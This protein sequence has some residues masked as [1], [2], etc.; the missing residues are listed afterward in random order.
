MAGFDDFPVP[1]VPAGTS[2]HDII[3]KLLIPGTPFEVGDVVVD[4][5]TFKGFKQSPANMRQMLMFVMAHGDLDAIV[6]EGER[7]SFGDVLRKSA[8]LARALV[9]D[10]GVK[11][12]DRVAIAMRN[13]PEWIF[14][15]LAITSIGGVA[16]ALNAWWGAEEL[17][18]A[19]KDCGAK[20]VIADEKRA[21][22]IQT[23]SK[24]DGI[25][26]IV[27]RPEGEMPA[28]DVDLATL[29][30]G[31]DMA[32]PEV[33]V[34]PDD[35]MH[36]LYTSGS[37]GF[38][39]GAVHTH[40]STVTS[41]MMWLVMALALKVSR[42]S[43]DESIQIATLV[44]VP[45]FHVTGLIP[46]MLVSLMIGRKLVVMHKW[47]VDRACQLIEEEKVTGFTGV[48][49][50]GYELSVYEG[51]T[52]YD[53]SSLQD[54]GGGGAARPKEHVRLL[55]D[56]LNV[57]PGLGYGL[58]ETNAMG[59][60]NTDTDYVGRPTSTGKA[61][62]PFVEL[63]IMDPDTLE[64]M[65]TGER[66]EIWFKGLF[67]AR[68]Y[69]G[70]EEDTATSFPNGWFRSG[71]VGYVDDEGFLFIVDRLKDIIIRG[72]ENISTIEVESAL[73]GLDGV[74]NVLVMGLPC[75]IMGE[76]VGAVIQR[77]D[78]TIDKKSI[79]DAV[80][81]HLAKYKIPEQIWLVDD[82]FPS[83]ASGKID[84]NFMK[85]EYAKR[86]Q[87]KLAAEGAKA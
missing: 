70:R 60:V 17:H 27:A 67:N 48:P 26:I 55:E 69:W 72:G 3:P 10:Y 76:R 79:L 59:C 23:F 47:D 58:T 1:Q 46:V 63:A 71:D 82:D 18:F 49:T 14:A 54:I 13:Y 9:L 20:L 50:M 74:K 78:P 57:K 6:Y 42:Q 40:R 66:G 37:T 44:A 24:A 75:V 16:V 62:T 45:F 19:F 12:G 84:K 21:S 30:E 4:G 64:E 7:Y 43:E 65:P 35:D 87:E 39:K 15:F 5:V 83:I 31:D 2:I 85:A 22:H 53:M 73:H 52:K 56:N 29:L 11:K 28:G 61:I 34:Q 51:R 25:K 86:W 80:S 36:M 41:L 8:A 81:A 38:P 77:A 68:G 32:F 33:D